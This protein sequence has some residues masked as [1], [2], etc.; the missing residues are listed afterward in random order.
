M[1]LDKFI[2]PKL[3]RTRPIFAVPTAVFFVLLGFI[4]SLLV[5]SSQISVVMIA[6][7]RLLILP[8]VIKIFEFDELDVDIEGLNKEDLKKWVVKCFRDGFSPQ[9]IKDN[10]IRDN[11]DKLD[12]L[13]LD[14][15]VID[16]VKEDYLR[17][18]N[19]FS[20]HKKTIEFYINLFFGM[21]IAYAILY[22]VLPFDVGSEVFENQL[23]VLTPGP[24]GFFGYGRLF[25]EIIKNNL[26]ITFVCVLLSLLYGSG[27]IFILNYNASIAGVLYGSSIRSILGGGVGFLA[28]PYSFIPHTVIEI[29][30]YL[31]AAISGAILSKAAAGVLPGHPRI[32]IKDGLLYLA[33]AIILIFVGAAVEVT[34]PFTFL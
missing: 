21:F 23:D 34:V 22:S 24:R 19:P 11:L 29:L 33:I 3:L 8:Y 28:N 12:S 32:L 9:Q 25:W 30:A 20:R 14:L 7:S 5:F 2:D 26:I 31:F 17:F 4:S 13:M 10:L 18:S 1:V 27:A 15:G 6:L 16:E